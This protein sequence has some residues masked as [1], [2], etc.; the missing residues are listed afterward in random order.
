MSIGKIEVKYHQVPVTLEDNFNTVLVMY[1][2]YLVYTPADGSPPQVLTASASSGVPDGNVLKSLLKAKY[3]TEE[4]FGYIQVLDTPYS[5]YLLMLGGLEGSAE[6]IL[7]SND[8]KVLSELWQILQKSAKEFNDLQLKYIP[9]AMNSNTFVDHIIQEAMSI[10]PESGLRLP[11]KDNGG[12]N[13]FYCPGSIGNEFSIKDHLQHISSKDESTEFAQKIKNLKSLDILNNVPNSNIVC[14]VGD[15]EKCT[16][17]IFTDVI[18]GGMGD[19]RDVIYGG[20]GNDYVFAGDGNDDLYGESGN[21]ILFG[22]GGNDNL[23]GG[24]G[25]DYLYGGADNDKLYGGTGLNY[26]YRQF[27]GQSLI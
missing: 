10:M 22:G 21:D 2:K 4:P 9:D 11:I 26:L 16:G 7:Y 20:G 14:N 17:T 23:Y 8:H 25:D 24:D 1:H 6:P 12:G 19:K 3:T 27:R 5:D 18:F 15:A 13:G